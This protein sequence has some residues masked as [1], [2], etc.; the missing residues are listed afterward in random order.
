M[1]SNSKPWK[2]VLCSFSSLALIAL[3]AFLF[4]PAQV[5]P[6][7][8]D[9]AGWMDED[10]GYR[11]SMTVS[12]STNETLTDYQV[13]LTAYYGTGTDSGSSVY[14]NYHAQDD[15][16]DIRF[17]TDDGETPLSYW[18]ESYTAG[19]SAVVWVE[20]DSIPGSDSAAFYIY[21]GNSGVSSASNA[22]NTMWLYENF[23]DLNTGN[24]H[25]QQGW[26]NTSSNTSTANVVTSQYSSGTK[27]LET[28]GVA[29][30]AGVGAYKVNNDQAKNLMAE[31]KMMAAPGTNKWNRLFYVRESN[32]ENAILSI[33]HD[34]YLYYCG[35][36][37]WNSS[38]I[39]WTGDTWYTMKV[40]IKS[41]NTQTVYFNDNL[42]VS[43]VA[44]HE[45]M[46]NG[47]N[48]VLLCSVC[49]GYDVTTTTYY[50]DLIVRKYV[51][52]EPAIT[53][54]GSEEER[55][56]TTPPAPIDDLVVA[57]VDADTLVLAWTATGDDGYVGVAAAYHIRYAASPIT[58]ASW[59]TATEVSG[60]PTPQ[61]AG[62]KQA[63][64][65]T[66]NLST[67]TYYFAIRAEDDNENLSDIYF[68]GGTIQ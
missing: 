22:R 13:K 7:S 23:D 34:G 51:T 21:Y 53:A 24:I 65:V 41:D 29:G 8:A 28:V 6:V 47:I 32:L 1:K 64:I 40:I 62:K 18:V 60:E 50:D 59:A 3:I 16:D 31:V 57:S 46:A 56:D 39:A 45:N 33:W 27:S 49:S 20:C 14:L 43:N 25:G 37:G 35:S 52:P 61:E 19:T 63:Y 54:W 10:W 15:F 42:I 58:T 30:T 2:S 48:H 12:N 67:G 4:L 9:T 17:T 36:S 55:P 68:P 38:G 11:K 44:L 66:D 26:I 5:L